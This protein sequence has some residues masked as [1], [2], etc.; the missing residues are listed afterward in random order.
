[1][2]KEIVNAVI[3]K[4]IFDALME[5]ERARPSNTRP[6]EYDLLYQQEEAETRRVR[7]E[8][9]LEDLRE[10]LAFI[11]ESYGYQYE[12]PILTEDGEELILRS[13]DAFVKRYASDLKDSMRSAMPG[14]VYI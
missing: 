4:G 6:A 8:A 5:T 7:A 11:A 14:M 10:A 2:S 3:A 1:M 13:W 12:K 9:R